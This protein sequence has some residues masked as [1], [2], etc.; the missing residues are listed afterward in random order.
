MRLQGMGRS[1]HMLGHIIEPEWSGFV[2]PD[3]P[4]GR[5]PGVVLVQMATSLCR[6]Q[7]GAMY[8]EAILRASFHAGWPTLGGVPGRLV[9]IP[10]ARL[11]RQEPIA[12]RRSAGCTILNTY[13]SGLTTRVLGQWECSMALPETRN[14][15]PDE[16]TVSGCEEPRISGAQRWRRMVDCWS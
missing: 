10:Q 9:L 3:R 11:I 12:C 13:S 1:S 5:L 14:T 6:R 16:A 15:P 8:G 7:S 4:D 2:E